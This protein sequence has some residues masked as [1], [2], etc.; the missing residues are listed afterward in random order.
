MLP[1][2]PLRLPG[3]LVLL[4][5]VLPWPCC[6]SSATMALMEDF[7]M[8]KLLY[9]LTWAREGRQVCALC[10]AM[11][12]QHLP[13]V[14]G[15]HPQGFASQRGAHILGSTYVSACGCQLGWPGT[16]TGQYEC[17]LAN[18][19]QPGADQRMQTYTLPG[20]CVVAKEAHPHLQGPTW[21]RPQIGC[22][23]YGGVCAG[24]CDCIGLVQASLCLVH[25]APWAL[26]TFPH[27]AATIA[28]QLQLY[29]LCEL[30][31]PL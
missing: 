24:M 16:H 23:F 3:L 10:H 20:V 11:Q 27:L 19:S 8:L 7:R 29:T 30:E 5:V 28:F 2:P 13:C 6:A 31:M 4:L 9:R 14:H 25:I 21:F 22:V 18:I 1:P 17:L 15:S 12:K 26:H